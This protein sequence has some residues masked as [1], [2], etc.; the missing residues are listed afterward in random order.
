MYRVGLRGLDWKQEDQL[1][2]CC[3]QH[4]RENKGLAQILLSVYYMAVR[5]LVGMDFKGTWVTHLDYF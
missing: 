2:D 3:Y 4:Q 1:G 5:A